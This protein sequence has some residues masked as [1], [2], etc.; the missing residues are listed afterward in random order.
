V[1]ATGPSGKPNEKLADAS[2]R[3]CFLFAAAEAKKLLDK[4]GAAYT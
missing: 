4:I 2:P 1:L 3:E